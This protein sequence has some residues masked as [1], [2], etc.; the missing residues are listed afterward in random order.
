[1]SPLLK[2]CSR[3]CVMVSALPVFQQR[4]VR[5]SPPLQRCFIC[6]CRGKLRSVALR[7]GFSSPVG[8]VGFA[9]FI[10]N[11][12]GGILLS[13]T[14]SAPRNSEFRI[15]K[16]EL[17]WGVFFMTCPASFTNSLLAAFVPRTPCAGVA[18]T[19]SRATKYAKR[20]L[21][22]WAFTTIHLSAVVKRKVPTPH[23]LRR[24]TVHRGEF[25]KSVKSV[26]RYKV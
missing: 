15:S 22:Y 2:T 23:G 3:S 18:H 10:G 26:P 5:H 16:S 4:I 13:V 21:G 6:S 25:I 12:F 17:Y 7:Q 9:F 19:L 8:D 20:P 11:Y 14:R 1:M 24:E